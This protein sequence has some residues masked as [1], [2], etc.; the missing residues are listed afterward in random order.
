MFSIFNIFKNKK[1]NQAPAKGHYVVIKPKAYEAAKVNR[2]TWSW[3][4]YK[5]TADQIIYKFL[6]VLVARSCNEYMNDPHAVKFLSLLENNVIGDKGISLQA[7]A[8][9]QNGELDQK[10][11]EAHEKAWKEW[12]KAKYC[13]VKQQQNFIGLC[14]LAIKTCAREGECLIRIVKGKNAGAWGF[15]LQLIDPRRLDIDK[16]DVSIQPNGNFIRFGIEFNSYGKPLKYYIKRY[17]DDLLNQTYGEPYDVIP[18][19]EIIHLFLPQFIDQKRGIPWFAPVL[20]HMNMLNG[21]EVAAVEHARAGACQMGFITNSD[22]EAYDDEDDKTN[23]DM[24][25]EASPATFHELPPGYKVEKFDPNYPNGEFDVFSKSI[26]RSIAVGLNA[27][28]SSVSGDLSSV[29]FSSLRQGILDE[30]EVWKGLQEWFKSGFCEKVH[31]YWLKYSLLYS[32]IKCGNGYLKPERIEKYKNV[33]WSMRRWSWVD[34]V[35]DVNAAAISVQNGFRSRSDVIR[36]QGRDPDDVWN[37]VEKENETIKTK[38][39]LIKDEVIRDVGEESEPE[40]TK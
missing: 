36:E 21:F 39:I 26:L 27:G 31:A 30:R 2:L 20:M 6:K 5:Y 1:N 4:T 7:Q 28:Y 24:E 12:Q 22:P 17:D 29:N 10:A 11:N 37:E 38:G 8:K 25:I 35:K 23:M 40:T 15:A 18:A 19:D 9:D 33:T 16:N 32:R 14:K 13:D 3:N 34:P